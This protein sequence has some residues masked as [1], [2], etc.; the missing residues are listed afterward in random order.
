MYVIKKIVFFPLKEKGKLPTTSIATTTKHQPAASGFQNKL[1]EKNKKNYFPRKVEHSF[2]PRNGP[3]AVFDMNSCECRQVLQRTRCSRGPQRERS[4]LCPNGSES[5]C[6]AA[7]ASS[8]PASPP[9]GLKLEFFEVGL[10]NNHWLSLKS[11]KWLS[12]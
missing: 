9:N 5:S 7:A 11:F 4:Q 12:Q 10:L 2:E 6:L 8:L 1:G 3:K